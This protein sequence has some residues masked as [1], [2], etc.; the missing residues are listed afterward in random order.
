MVWRGP[1]IAGAIKQ[2]WTD[3][4]WGEVDY[5]FVG[6][7]PGTGDAPLTVFQSLP[8]SG[9]LIVTSPPGTGL[10]DRLQGG[11]NGKDDGCPS[12]GLG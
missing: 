12:V 8:L 10:H 2:F 5:M 1:V 9:I 6:M 4:V 7:P 3:V 11:G